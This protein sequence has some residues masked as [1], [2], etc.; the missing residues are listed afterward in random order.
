MIVVGSLFACSALA[1]DVGHEWDRGC[2]DA[3]G[4]SYD[5]SKHSAESEEGWKAC[6]KN[7]RSAGWAQSAALPV[8][9]FNPGW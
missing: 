8:V 6:N 1:A 7:K 2:S 4:G 5:C 9:R 3:K